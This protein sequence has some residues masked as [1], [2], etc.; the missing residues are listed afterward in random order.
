MKEKKKKER[1]EVNLRFCCGYL[2]FAFE[3]SCPYV[4]ENGKWTSADGFGSGLVAMEWYL[5]APLFP[6]GLSCYHCWRIILVCH[7]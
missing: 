3:I 1:R 6:P 5:V 7:K 4:T 2:S